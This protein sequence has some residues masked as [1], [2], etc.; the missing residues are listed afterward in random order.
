MLYFLR[1]DPRLLA[2]GFL[3]AFGSG[4]GQTYFIALFSGNLRAEYG[5]SH[6]GFGAV[7]AAA[8]ILSAA[9]ITLTGRWI[10]HIDLRR[11]TVIVVVLLA[12]A[13]LAMALAWNMA[14]FFVAIFLLRQMGQGLMSHTAVTAQARYY[15]S[16]RGRAV[17]TAGMGHPFA[18]AVLPPAAILLMAAIGW[19]ES[20]FVI[21]AAVV[22]FILPLS[23]WLL[24]G[25]G[26]RHEAHLVATRADVAREGGRAA[27]G[28]RDWTRGEVLRDHRFY[29]LLPVILAPAF[30]GTGIFFHQ[31]LLVESKG[32]PV[33]LWA[34]SF[35]A[36]AASHVAAA[37]VFGIVVDRVGT[38]RTLPYLLAP[39]GLACLQ[40]AF[41][42]HSSAIWGFMVLAGLT[43]GMVTTFFGTFWPEAYGTRHLGAIRSAGLALMVFSSALSPVFMGVLLDWGVTIESL[44]LAFALYCGGA[45]ALGLV[46]ARLYAKAG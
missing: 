30:I 22:I 32:W 27:N 23:L 28:V 44:T 35:V 33:D 6:G 41:S 15:V 4:F 40:L 19:R 26:A 16:A 31:I 34:A 20:W 2:Y 45:S 39:L 37:L 46:A 38:R 29:V 25:H 21:A 5:I 3:L 7:Y 24:R 10:D 14:S 18:Q 43:V 17:A 8:T 13:C 12:A 36:F 42:D 11:W 9:V 1:A